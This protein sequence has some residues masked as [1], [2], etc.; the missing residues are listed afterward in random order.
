MIKIK[1]ILFIV[2]FAVFVL[3]STSQ[4]LIHPKGSFLGYHPFDTK[5][6]DLFDENALD[7]NYQWVFEPNVMVSV[8]TY[9]RGTKL[10]WR[11]MPGFYVDGA[12]QPALFFHVGIKYRILQIFRSSFDLAVGPTYNFRQDWHK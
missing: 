5:N 6:R 3:P 10:S 1:R 9:L 11:F 8:E 2:V 4:T 7:A 12:A